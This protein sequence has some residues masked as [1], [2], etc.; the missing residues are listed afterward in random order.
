MGRRVPGGGHR[1]HCAHQC[2]AGILVCEER[3][4]LALESLEVAGLGHGETW[5]NLTLWCAIFWGEDMGGD[6]SLCGGLCGNCGLVVWV[7]KWE[8]IWDHWVAANENGDAV[9]WVPTLYRA[10]WYK[11]PAV[12]W[13]CAPWAFLL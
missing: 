10:C 7:S 4:G 1:V 3:F 2:Y 12:A 9:R 5:D 11:A 13:L 6:G 8:W